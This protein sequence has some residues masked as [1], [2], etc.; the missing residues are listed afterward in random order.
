MI[1]V[2]VRK[3]ISV[4][5]F[6][7]T[8]VLIF[9]TDVVAQLS[10]SADRLFAARIP[11]DLIF[12]D[13]ELDENGCSDTISVIVHK[14]DPEMPLPEDAPAELG[15]LPTPLLSSLL[16]GK[17]IFPNQCGMQD[18]ASDLAN[19]RADSAA[20]RQVAVIVVGDEGR[21]CFSGG[22]A[23]PLE[24]LILLWR[25]G[26]ITGWMSCQGQS[27]TFQYYPPYRDPAD[28]NRFGVNVSAISAEQFD[29]ITRSAGDFMSKIM[30]FVPESL[31]DAYGRVALDNSPI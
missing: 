12:E 16:V 24:K 4:A 20:I 13:C 7:G 10:T 22:S 28:E 14:I 9:E 30:G 23:D 18:L 26:L 2:S 3:I 29:S 5:M 15:L 6:A 19:W 17:R 21:K 31:Q 25:S 8:A 27:C 1:S 11:A